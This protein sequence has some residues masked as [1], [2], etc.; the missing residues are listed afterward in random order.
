MLLEFSQ[1]W[2]LCDRS[3]RKKPEAVVP[4]FAY[5]VFVVQ[6]RYNIHTIEKEG[7]PCS[8]ANS[9]E[10]F[11]SMQQTFRFI[12]SS[13][14][15]MLSGMPWGKK[16][17]FHIFIKIE[18]KFIHHVAQLQALFAEKHLQWRKPMRGA[19]HWSQWCWKMPWHRVSFIRVFLGIT[20]CPALPQITFY[21]FIFV[22]TIEIC[23]LCKLVI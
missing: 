17:N 10:F 7:F 20:V 9:S 2:D 16:S 14:F 4:S 5:I 3:K 21:I 11:S 23:H 19:S 12:F 8:L 15:L 18:F 6:F 13:N 22:I 1:L